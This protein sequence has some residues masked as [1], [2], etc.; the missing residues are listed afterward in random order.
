M[1]PSASEPAV[2]E[3][4]R[5]LPTVAEHDIWKFA[6]TAFKEQDYEVAAMHFRKLGPKSRALYNVAICY[7][8]M[9]DLDS[10]VY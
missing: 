7:V 9:D 4:A 8:L 6:I 5:L 2:N 3:E 1:K 10:A